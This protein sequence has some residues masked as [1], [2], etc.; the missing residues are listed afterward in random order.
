MQ[1]LFML[2]VAYCYNGIFYYLSRLLKLDTFN[3]VA[4]KDNDPEL[5]VVKVNVH[6]CLSLISMG[7]VQLHSA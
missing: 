7:I 6:M 5:V 3:C 2:T 4:N 1:K